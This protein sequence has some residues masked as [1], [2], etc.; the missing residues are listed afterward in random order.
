MAE[1]GEGIA[2][3]NQGKDRTSSKISSNNKIQDPTGQQQHLHINWSNLSQN[4]QEN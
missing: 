4:F 1:R 3:P 2:S